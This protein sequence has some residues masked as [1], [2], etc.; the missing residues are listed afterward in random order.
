MVNY[1]KVTPNVEAI[2]YSHE[3]ND[4]TVRALSVACELEYSVAHKLIKDKT[5]R[6]DTGA[7]YGFPVF[8]DK[9]IPHIKKLHPKPWEKE[10]KIGTLSKFVRD[11]PT[12]TWILLKSGHAFALVN[13]VVYD[14]WQPGPKTQIKQAW[15]I[16]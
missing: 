10:K 4:C 15:Q 7:C 5:G 1:I 16:K 6:K 14:S 8:M 13:G 12:G 3:R 9:Y 11:N 2:G